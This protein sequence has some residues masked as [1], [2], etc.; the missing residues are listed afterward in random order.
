[1]GRQ[2]SRNGEQRPCHSGEELRCGV[3]CCIVAIVSPGHAVSGP[4]VRRSEH[5]RRHPRFIRLIDAVTDDV[6]LRFVMS[7]CGHVVHRQH[8]FPGYGGT[9]VGCQVLRA[10]DIALVACEMATDET[11]DELVHVHAGGAGDSDL[12]GEEQV[13][14]RKHVRGGPYG[15][16]KSDSSPQAAPGWPECTWSVTR[17]GQTA[18]AEG[19]SG[20]ETARH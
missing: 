13:L 3:G 7:A 11:I 14:E 16:R 6:H 9:A 12:V 2:T 8:A 10:D 15:S 19:R 20:L 5:H 1:M 17:V 4:A 18:T